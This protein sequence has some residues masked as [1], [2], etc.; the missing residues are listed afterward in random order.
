MDVSKSNTIL[1][2]R[3]RLEGAIPLDRKKR[4]AWAAPVGMKRPRPV[5]IILWLNLNTSSHLVP[6]LKRNVSH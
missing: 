1:V 3:I 4:L 5:F 2:R 6:R